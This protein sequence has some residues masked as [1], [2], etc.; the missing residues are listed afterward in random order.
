M[1]VH[2]EIAALQDEMKS[3]RRDFHAHPEIGFEERRTSDIVAE[4]L[5][6]WGIEVHRGIG[7]TGV[8]GVLRGR[9]GNRAVGLRADMDA[10]AMDEENDV[11][12]RSTIPNRMHA[13]GHDGHTTML[14]GAAKH[15]ART[16][17]FS[18]T[19]NFIFQPAEEGLAGAKAMIDDGLFDRFPC[20][21]VYAI[22]NDPNTDIGLVNVRPGGM[23][24]A[25]DY[26]EITVHGKGCHGGQPHLGIDPI[27]AAAGVINAIQTISSRRADPLDTVVISICQING[28][29]VNIV[30]PEQVVLRGSVRTLKRKTRDDVELWFKTAVESAAAAQ[31]ARTTIN[32]DR[33]YPPTINTALESGIAASAAR[34]VV[35]ENNIL[36]DEPSWTAGEDFAF[37]LEEKPGAY[38]FFGQRGTS[39]GGVALHNPKYDFNDDLL[40]VG[41]GFFVSLV[42]RVLGKE[43][44]STQ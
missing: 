31:G 25:V 7:V 1:N 6:S 38:A 27:V 13:C 24:A 12:H 11:E 29:S 19:I 40:P 32:Y 14:L 9:P 37:M 5:Q 17:D 28:G 16:R 43:S 20:D 36:T 34:S 41:A 21:S 4:K 23:L 44:V 15:L 3:W 39:H 26:F 35:G 22:H 42:E 33:A 2:P 8:V 10:L 30:V 18:G